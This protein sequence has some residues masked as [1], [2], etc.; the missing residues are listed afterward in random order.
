M[1][2]KIKLSDGQLMPEIV[3]GSDWIDLRANETIKL[4]APF[5]N[6]LNG[7][8]DRRTVEFENK[9]VDLGIRMQLPEGYEAVVLPRSSTYNK[10]GVTLANSQGVIDNSYKGDNDVW[11][12][13]AIAYRDVTINKGDRVCQFRI[14][15]KQTATRKQKLKWLLW[16]GKIEFIKVDSLNNINRGGHGSTGLK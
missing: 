10:V 13:N 6:T 11:F 1:K 5:A 14:Q 7:K 4:K 15:L 16:N 12:F 9:L 3:E 8:R 2:I